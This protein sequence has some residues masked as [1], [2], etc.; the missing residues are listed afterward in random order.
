[1]SRWMAVVAAVGA[2]L[3]AA[4]SAGTAA[5]AEADAGKLV[6]QLHAPAQF[7]FACYYA[8]LWQGYYQAAG[9]TVE[10]K[11][12]EPRPAAGAAA[13]DPVREVSE[14][15]AQ[16]ATGSA[17]LVV[18]TAQGLPLLLLAPIFQHSGAAVY[19]RAD[20]DFAGPGALTK[21]RLGRLPASDILDIEL[22]TALAAEGID[23]A[24]LKS[25]L[26]EPG[27]AAAALADKSIDAAIGAA[28]D[29]PFAAREK[30][31]ALKS[32]N[33]ADY[34]VEFYGDTLFTLRRRN[35]AEPQLVRSFRAA[36]LKGW[37][38]ALDHPEE[39]A[40]RLAGE[41]PAPPGIADA[42]G[43][44]RYQAD[45]AR[46]LARYPEVALGHSNPERW[47]RIEAAMVGVGALLRTA[48]ADAFVYDPDAEARSRTDLRALVILGATGI[49]GLAILGWLFV[50]WRRRPLPAVAAAA[51]AEA[52]ESSP[53]LPSHEPAH[54][55]LP[56]DLNAL[57]TRLEGRMRQRAGRRVGL[58]LSLVPEP[59]RAR[60]AAPTVEALVLDLVAAAAADLKGSG[61]LIVGARNQ[62]LDGAESG[63]FVRL[64][65]RDSGPGLS[66]DALDQIFDPAVTPRPTA[67]AAAASMHALGGFAR[68]E[69]AEG[70]GTAVHLYFARE[71]APARFKFAR[72]AE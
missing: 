50:A 69:S 39:I 13:L 58:R 45:V 25:V 51:P 63:D 71:T 42:A 53:P 17:E 43:F 10:I 47:E 27:R 11:P 23:Q 22:A 15:K 40:R 14:G 38:Y 6:L 37:A 61:E 67:A 21:A 36:S 55:K 46:R 49:I 5:S 65:V 34:R 56:A 52:P 66:E 35:A 3:G 24:K 19:Y 54:E 4:L 9:L 62:T 48:D 12:G 32:F 30:G 72:A 31:L 33:P 28:W 41:F 29:L 7:E 1:M 70:V 18:R 20:G 64:T 60:A 57:L 16:F 8:A 59:W 26:L 68:V 44:A 2:A